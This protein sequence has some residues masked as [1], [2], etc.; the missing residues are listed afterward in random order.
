[1]GRGAVAR[2]PRLRAVHVDG[3]PGCDALRLV[4][5]GG[6][7]PRMGGV[8]PEQAARRRDWLL[9]VAA[10]LAFS[11][12]FGTYSGLFPNFAAQHLGLTRGQLGLRQ[13]LREVPGLLTAG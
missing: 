4:A 3:A 12:G 8:T 5:R 9:L 1:R 2:G 7:R 6:A 11:F 13:S 10:T